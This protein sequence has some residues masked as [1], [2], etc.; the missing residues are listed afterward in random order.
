[1]K[2]IGQMFPRIVNLSINNNASSL[3]FYTL[4]MLIFL[5]M[6]PL[7]DCMALHM[8]IS[9]SG[10]NVDCDN[11]L[12]NMISTISLDNWIAFIMIGHILSQFGIPQELA[13][14]CFGVQ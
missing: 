10:N 14:T 7:M 3:S 9:R 11:K 2:F 13:T 1:M 12:S 5:S 6:L 4:H 8:S